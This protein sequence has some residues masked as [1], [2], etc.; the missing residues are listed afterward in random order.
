M[1]GDVAYISLTQATRLLGVSRTVVERLIE[2]G[3]L[4][5]FEDQLDARRKLVREADITRLKAE[6]YKRMETAA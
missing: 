2:D 1:S 5:V 4:A 6:R 3:K